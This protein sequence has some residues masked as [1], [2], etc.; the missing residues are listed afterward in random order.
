[1]SKTNVVDLRALF[2]SR[3]KATSAAQELIR[4]HSVHAGTT[5]EASE[6]SWIELLREYLPNRYMVARG[7]VIDC[8]QECSDQIDILIFDR[9][10]S[11]FIVNV[12]G[13]TYVPAESVYAVFEVKQDISK[14]HIEYASAKA[15][16]VRRL[17]RTSV[18]INTAGGRLEGLPPFH[19][20]AG[21]LTLSCSWEGGLGSHFREHLASAWKDED[22]RLELGCVLDAGG[23]RLTS[24]NNQPFAVETS[25]PETSLMHFT[26]SLFKTLRDLGTVRALDVDSYLKWI[27]EHE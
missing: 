1:M 6:S 10:Y 20:P 3:Q 8:E 15:A 22:N 24:Q 26:L 21:L 2:K 9:Q 11:P 19:I 14:A 18:P 4:E 27:E 7:F 5:G 17:K 12:E 23:F 25:G 16:S 13:M